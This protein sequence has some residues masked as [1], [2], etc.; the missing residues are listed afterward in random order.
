MYFRYIIIFTILLFILK[1]LSSP[2]DNND[3]SSNK[4][5]I[6]KLEMSAD[7]A[8]NIQVEV[9]DE[10]LA[11]G[12][13]SYSNSEIKVDPK[14]VAD[15][16]DETP[17]E[18]ISNEECQTPK[19]YETSKRILSKIDFTVDPCEDFYQFSCGTW[20][21]ENEIPMSDSTINVFREIGKNN[22][23]IIHQILEGEYPVDKNLSP[24]DQALDKK[25]FNKIKTIY[26]TCMDETAI[27]KQGKKPILNL[28][29][30]FD[31]YNKKLKY[32]G[33]DGLSSL[34]ANLQQYDVNIVFNYQISDDFVNPKLNAFI[35]TQPELFLIVDQYKDEVDVSHF[36]AMITETLNGLFKDQKKERNIEEMADR[37]VEFEKKLS[38]I[39]IP[40]E[41]LEEPEEIYHPTTIGEL[42]KLYPNINWK[43]YLS[44]LYKNS[45]IKTTVDDDTY[46]VNETP[47]YFEG[48]NKILDE[49]DI[50]TLI[51]Y[52]E[53]KIISKFIRYISED[54]SKPYI[55]FV[56]SLSGVEEEKERY[57]I[58]TEIT[59][60]LMGNA[61]GKYFAQ[62]AF[63]G[64]SK[65]IAKEH[66]ANIKQAMIDR[67]PK[68]SWLDKATADYA[69][70]KV[71]KLIYEKIGYPDYIFNPKELLEKDYE[72]FDVDPHILFNTL[73]NFKVFNIN[74][75]NK[76]IDNPV[77][78]SEWFMKPYTVNLY[79]NTG[80]NSINSPAGIL[81]PP[82]FD[83]QQP[84]YLNY[85]AIGSLIGHEL[86]HAFDTMGSLYDIN[87]VLN[88]WWT[89]STYNEF[90][91]L[92]MCFEDQ[93]NQYKIEVS[94]GKEINMNGKITLG[95]NIA[96]NGG[97]SRSLEAWKLSRR[98]AKKF[99]ERNKALPGLSNFTTE[100]LFYIAFGQLYCEKITPEM[101]EIDNENDPHSQGKYRVIGTLSNNEHFA[102]VF[103]CPK[104]SPMNPEK[105][106][107]IW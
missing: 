34:I 69:T 97:I 8:S 37:I 76:K 90:N 55:D 57:K 50:D 88:N 72:G 39:L 24:E 95:E 30:R 60:N 17:S 26:R 59:E 31:L 12:V 52:S 32:E 47:K 99:N 64:N 41:D 51:Y 42:M 80:D 1:V 96:D 89:N 56:N 20:M 84:D 86:T 13:N 46:V 83:A 73:V 94:D 16:E 9:S 29:N 101:A 75:Y 43:L 6:S 92:T 93:Y 106:C 23:E 10:G 105:K 78:F 36:K 18:I 45:D 38:E 3:L 68:M 62:K 67:I 28:L 91:K 15:P 58:C 2:I 21:K 54:F 48:L 35:L 14:V 4:D 49:T 27:K 70:E 77:D 44:T 102:K 107:L 33:V 85:G 25:I 103:N 40:N 81:Q 71:N 53:W 100:Q 98:D 65:E 74:K 19:C 61:L 63:K 5:K 87:G 104:N 66:I 22:K 11:N 82:L 7:D 79:Y